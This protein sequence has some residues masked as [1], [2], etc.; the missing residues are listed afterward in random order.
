MNTNEPLDMNDQRILDRLVDGELPPQQERAVLRQLE[1]TPEGWRRCALTFLENRLWYNE[2]QHL[3]ALRKPV[4]HPA[5]PR[6]TDRGSW[7]NH[8]TWA[9]ALAALFLLAV[10]IG[11]ML[12][13]WW[14]SESA[15]TGPTIA[16]QPATPSTIAAAQPEPPSGP[17]ARVMK[18]PV[19]A[20]AADQPVG[21]LTF[22]DDSGHSVEVP[23]FDW[24]RQN[25]DRLLFQPEP[26]PQELVHSLKRH[27]V[28]R[29]QRYVPVQLKDG[30]HVLVPIQE[31]DIVPVTGTAY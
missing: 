25:A 28:R 18:P 14:P 30:R 1:Q 16:S 21:N 24:N 29:H 17:S 10:S 26:L 22:V 19:L 9:L 6:H 27:E 31:L 23:V 12:P 3:P 7:H 20:A 11:Q 8:W 13:P 4:A 15:P 5:P 2:I